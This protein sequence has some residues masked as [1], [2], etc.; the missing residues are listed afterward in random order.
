M[1]GGAWWGLSSRVTKSQTLLRDQTTTRETRKGGGMA[2]TDILVG[3]EC[4]G[5]DLR[6]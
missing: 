2:S 5:K 1:D 3:K 6:E 4:L